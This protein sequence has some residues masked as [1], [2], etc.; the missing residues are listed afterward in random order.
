MEQSMLG[1]G[2]ITSLIL[3]SVS[4]GGCAVPTAVDPLPYYRNDGRDGEIV[5]TQELCR[6]YSRYGFASGNC[7]DPDWGVRLFSEADLDSTELQSARNE[8]QNSILSVSTTMCRNFKQTLDRRSR[9]H[10]LHSETLALFLSAGAAIGVGGSEQIAKGFAAIAGASTGYGRM[11]DDRYVND[12]ETTQQGIELARRRVFQQI[13]SQQEK[14]L[15]E[16]PLSRAVN[17]AIRYH[18]VCNVTEG[19]SETSRSISEEFSELSV[20][21]REESEDDSE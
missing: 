6:L 21:D 4:M 19:K 9:G 14:D 15:L 17:D 12:L 8:L 20:G 13:N 5:S 2:L 7:E 18:A 1:R 11:I 3:I 10:S 16:Y